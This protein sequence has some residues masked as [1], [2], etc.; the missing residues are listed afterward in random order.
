M[1][2]YSSGF[3]TQPPEGG[4]LREGWLIPFLK[5]VSTHSRPKAAGSAVA[6]RPAN[7]TGFNTQPPEGGWLSSKNIIEC[8]ARFNTQP[9]EGGWKI[10]SLSPFS[11][12]SFNTQPPEGG[13]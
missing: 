6:T 1:E 8:I 12:I 4:W 11:L 10:N 7:E 5:T 9:P 3:N 2:T 13:W